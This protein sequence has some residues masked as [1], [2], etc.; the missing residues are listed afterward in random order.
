[1][2]ASVLCLSEL[3]IEILEKILL[4]LPGQDIVKVEVVRRVIAPQRD[5]ALTFHRT[6]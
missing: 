4:H 6:V 5:S 3:P 1:M 2:F